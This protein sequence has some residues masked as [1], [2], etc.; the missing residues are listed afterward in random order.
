M[1]SKIV[2]GL[3]I[4]VI[5][6]LSS[7]FVLTSQAWYNSPTPWS[8][9][10]HDSQHSGMGTS[11]APSDNSTLWTYDAIGDA[12]ARNVFVDGG[13]VF[14]IRGGDF[15]VLDETT[16]AFILS[17]TEGGGGYGGNIGGAY[18]NGKVYY[19]SYDYI[20]GRGTVYCY[21][22]TTGTQLWTYDTTP[23][24]IQHTPTVSGDRVYVGTLNN[25]TYCI[26]DGV[27]KWYK[28]LGGPIYPAP[29]VDGDLLC[30]GCDDGKLYAFNIS[31]AQPVSLWNFTVGNAIREPIIIKDDNVYLSGGNSHLYVLD[32]TNGQLIWSWKAGGNYD[33]EIAVAYGIVYVG[34]KA[35]G[36]STYPLYALYAN[37]TAGNYTNTSVEPRLWSDTAVTYGYTGIAVSGNTIFYC[38]Y[39]D[40]ILYARNALTGTR[41][42]SYK[43]DYSAL[44][45]IVADG[46]V[47]IA[48]QYRIYCIGASYP[49]VTNT[50]NLNVGGQAFTVAAT[51][52]S[53]IANL[54]TS[55]VTTTKN[56]S[57]TVESSQGTGMCNI[58]LPNSMLGGPYTLTVGGQPPWSS[59]TTAL[60]STH[61]NLYF[62][63]NGT[64]KYT[65]R[66]TGTTAI[67][68]FSA[69]MMILLS[70]IL[71]LTVAVLKKV[72]AT[73]KSQ[74]RHTKFQ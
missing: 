43:P 13:R 64:G 68:E 19:T 74:V 1:K 67:P 6:L 44:V 50:Y 3:V 65:A 55:T 11:A 4:A 56:M 20:Y 52:N 25:Y 26:E 34:V 37:V 40:R 53:T 63:Y 49:P 18:A 15:F 57:F 41:L 29:A 62:T 71:T 23:G 14:A 42:W 45:P 17:G 54:N 28:K 31:S 32:K 7:T 5:L 27:A 8:Q 12:R 2:L 73:G 59:V 66:I 24:Q 38:S 48:D 9:G 35:A 36:Q 69:P 61:T 39:G 16:G 30:I 70:G 46:H 58:T 10:Q 47:F 22:A 21:N 72:H 51:T 33:L 60:N